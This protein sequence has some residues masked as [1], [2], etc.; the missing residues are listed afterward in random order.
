ML[1]LS[2]SF[3]GVVI[4]FF[5]GVFSPAVMYD[6]CPKFELSFAC[7]FRRAGRK[8]FEVLGDSLCLF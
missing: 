7:R 3:S 6:F 4:E 5:R 1:P 2:E 8:V